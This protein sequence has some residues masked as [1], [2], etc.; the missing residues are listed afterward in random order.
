MKYHKTFTPQFI[1]DFFYM[2]KET[3]KKEW[4]LVA[5]INKEL[6]LQKKTKEL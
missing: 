1:K 4:E 3:L 6:C 5:L 2:D